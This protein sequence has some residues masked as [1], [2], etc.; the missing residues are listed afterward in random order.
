MIDPANA[1]EVLVKPYGSADAYHEYKAST[2]S[3]LYPG[4]RNEC[5]VEA[6]TNE[7][8]VVEIILHPLFRWKGSPDVRALVEIDGGT[9]STYGWFDSLKAATATTAKGSH[10]QYLR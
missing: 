10:R 6:I 5:Y 4:D 3:K 2:A 7:R 9:F 8:F 1:V